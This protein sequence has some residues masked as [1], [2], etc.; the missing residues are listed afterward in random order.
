M[1]HKWILDV[2]TD[3]RSF[4]QDNDLQLLADQLAQTTKVA[5]VEIAATSEERSLVTHGDSQHNRALFTGA[6]AQKGLC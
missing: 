3:L 5:S 2:L 6:G 4:A 1:G